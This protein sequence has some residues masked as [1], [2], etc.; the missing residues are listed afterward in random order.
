MDAEKTGE[1]KQLAVVNHRTNKV[2]RKEVR[3]VN[4]TEEAKEK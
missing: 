1:S 4:E 2:T 3:R